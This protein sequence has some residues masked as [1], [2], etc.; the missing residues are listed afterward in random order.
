M[1]FT[2]A[3]VLSAV[4]RSAGLRRRCLRM[5][6]A[7]A[8]AAG[9][10]AAVAQHG[11]AADMPPGAA[12][13]PRGFLWEARKGGAQVL[14]MGT[15]HLG[16][17]G[18]TTLPAG[19]AALLRGSAAL[20]LEADV[21]DA[22]RVQAA[23]QRHALRAPSTSGLD[24]ALP[25]PLRARVQQRIESAGL[26]PEI[27]WRFKPWALANNLV[28][29]EAMRGCLSP[30]YSTEAQLV[31]VARSAGLPVLELESVEAQ[32]ALFDAMPDGLSLAY[33]EEAVGGIERGESQREIADLVEAWRAGDDA[34]MARQVDRMR[35]AVKPVDRWVSAQL[36]ESRHPAM[37]D[38]IER[39]A[40]SGR[41]HLVA[42]GTLH[43]FG[44]EGL[45]AGLRA[46]G[47]SI[48]RLP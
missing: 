15:I 5:L 46:R 19:H 28:V 2:L 25:A 27:A 47:Y 30:A 39:M 21:F 16:R 3:A 4:F 36:I 33:L 40:A 31:A 23:M 37:L 42:V 18:Q 43:F 8:T 32:L 24:R 29:L 35:A 22:Q 12:G 1:N 14:L 26:A 38:R 6:L 13:A 17:D 34:A 48:T 44:P 11:T 7:L 45:L 10:S 20:V 41:L 9:G